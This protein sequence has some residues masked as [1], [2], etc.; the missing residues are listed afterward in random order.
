MAACPDLPKA[1]ERVKRYRIKPF[2]RDLYALR[3]KYGIL[4]RVE[5]RENDG[6]SVDPKK[7]GKADIDDMMVWFELTD[8]PDMDDKYHVTAT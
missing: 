2:M 1:P 8:Y 6:T 5:I 7:I 4:S 3:D